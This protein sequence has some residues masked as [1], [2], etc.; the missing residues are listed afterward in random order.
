MKLAKT[1]KPESKYHTEYDDDGFPLSAYLWIINDYL[2]YGR[3]ENRETKY[4]QNGVGKINWK[5]TMQA[6]PIISNGSIIYSEL[7]TERK[8]HRDD[9]ITEIYNFCVKS[10]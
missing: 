10:R 9:I 4:C 7:I 1:G 5:R 3:Y 2:K 6:Q 8:V